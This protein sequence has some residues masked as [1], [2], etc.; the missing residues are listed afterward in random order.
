MKIDLAGKVA[1]VTGGSRGIGHAIGRPSRWRAR[2]WPSSGA[3]ASRRRRP[4][5]VGHGGRAAT[6]VTWRRH[7]SGDDD[8]RGRAGLRA[9]RV[10][11]NTP[12]HARQPA[13]PHRRG[14]LDTVMTESQGRVLVTK[15]AAR[16][17]ISGAG[18]GS[19]TSR[20]WWYL[21]Q[22]GQSNYTVQGRSDRFT[23]SV[24]KELA[25]ATSW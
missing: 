18:G 7:P 15:H 13:V 19:S 5:P 21:R 1:V 23:K 22:Q 11:V 14:R 9:H 2:S 24:S 6:D 3:T 17:M 25:P 16:G 20:A 8:R 12:N 4:L 10:V